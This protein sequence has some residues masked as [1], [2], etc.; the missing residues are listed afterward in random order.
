MKVAVKNTANGICK[1]PHV[2]PAK[3]NKGFGIEAAKVT[4]K[5][6]FFLTYLNSASFILLIVSV[7][8]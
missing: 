3:S 5:K 7:A 1:W 4:V 8:C 6:A 2:S